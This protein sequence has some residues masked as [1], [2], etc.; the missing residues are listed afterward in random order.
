MSI[1]DVG[2]GCNVWAFNN[3]EPYVQRGVGNTL[4]STL[5]NAV[6]PFLQIFCGE[7]TI[8]TDYQAIVIQRN[9][10]SILKEGIITGSGQLDLE[11]S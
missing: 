4:N 7:G 8:G 3:L 9:T 6:E 11:V 1:V 10:N 5:D 2:R